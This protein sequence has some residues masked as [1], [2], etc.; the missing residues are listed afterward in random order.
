MIDGSEKLNRQLAFELQNLRVFEK[1]SSAMT[2]VT[3][4]RMAKSNRLAKQQLC[5]CITLF[6]A[7]LCCHY[8]TTT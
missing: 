8:K 5:T 7:L 2:T 4:K 3:S 1:C 6:C